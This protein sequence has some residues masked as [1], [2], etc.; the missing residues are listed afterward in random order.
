MF[1]FFK[2]LRGPEELML[3]PFVTP[4]LPEEGKHFKV[5][6]KHLWTPNEV[7]TDMQQDT[8]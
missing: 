1:S 8:K 4:N 5:R 2:G 6:V 3:G 7:T